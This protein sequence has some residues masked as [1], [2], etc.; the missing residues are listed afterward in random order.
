LSGNQLAY[1]IRLP[2]DT[3]KFLKCISI[4]VVD[5]SLYLCDNVPII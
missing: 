5:K 4:L 3:K 1:P 2:M